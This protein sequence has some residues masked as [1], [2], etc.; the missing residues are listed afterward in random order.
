MGGATAVIPRGSKALGDIAVK[1]VTSI[2]P[3]TNSASATGVPAELAADLTAFAASEPESLRLSHLDAWHARALTLLIRLH[4]HAED[5]A[6]ATLDRSIWEFL[7]R[8]V[9]R[10]AFAAPGI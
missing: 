7:Q 3:E 4:E 10:H 5:A 8:H 2:A 1:L 9:A 6:D